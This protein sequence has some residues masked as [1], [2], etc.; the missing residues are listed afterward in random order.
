MIKEVMFHEFRMAR[1]HTK[2]Q[3]H[4]ASSPVMK[5]GLRPTREMKLTARIAEKAFMAPMTYVPWRAVR[6][7]SP[8]DSSI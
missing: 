3:M 8:P 4:I 7:K 6:G 1:P 5:I 2:V